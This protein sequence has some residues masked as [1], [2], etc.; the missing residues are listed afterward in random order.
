MR[1]AVIFQQPAESL[2]TAYADSWPVVADFAGGEQKEVALALVVS[3]RVE[4]INEIGQRATQRGLAIR[5]TKAELR[6]RFANR[7]TR[8]VHKGDWPTRIRAALRRR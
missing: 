1:I 4:M 2:V 7:Y 8:I 5:H 3:L 6:H